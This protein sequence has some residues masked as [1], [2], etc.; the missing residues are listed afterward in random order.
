MFIWACFK[1]SY[2]NNIIIDDDH[3]CL[4]KLQIDPEPA[5][6]YEMGKI[7]G[8]INIYMAF[9]VLYQFLLTYCTYLARRYIN[10]HKNMPI[11][12]LIY[13]SG[14]TYEPQKNDMEM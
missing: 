1:E 4:T 7:D 11:Y 14:P 12:R 6:Q 9:Y 2:I 5:P 13:Y 3:T 10:K 8:V